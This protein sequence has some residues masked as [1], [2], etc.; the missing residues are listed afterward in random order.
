M[1][2]RWWLLLFALVIVFVL[3]LGVLV[4]HGSAARWEYPALFPARLSLR[5][6]LFLWASRRAIVGA[7][8]SSLAYSLAAVVLSVCLCLAPARVLARYQ[9]PGRL[10]LEIV[11]LSPVFIPAIAWGLGF[12]VVLLRG[13][14]ANRFIGV[15]VTL[16]AAA[17]PYMLRALIAGYQQVN[18][19]YDLCAA[20]LGASWW[21]RTRRVTLPLLFPSVVSGGTVVFLAAFSDYFLV[22]LVGGGVVRSFSGFLMPYLAAADYTLGAALTVVF[23]MVPLALL[24]LTDRLSRTLYR[25]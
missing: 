25:R 9:F 1:N 16:T 14:L 22:F 12:S 2:W 6:V 24:Y 3:P 17:Y 11:L 8:A 18:P 15:A 10:A 7:L 23:L 19:D 13:G 4:L 21:Y 20:S 5:G